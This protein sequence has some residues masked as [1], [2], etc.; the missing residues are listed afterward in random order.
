MQE[1]QQAIDMDFD[2][3]TT[4]LLST[5]ITA[6]VGFTAWI[7]TATQQ[8]MVTPLFTKQRLSDALA[9]MVGPNLATMITGTPTGA[10]MKLN[11]MGWANK[12]TIGGAIL[13]IANQ[14]TRKYTEK[15][16]DGVP[17]FIDAA[18][19]GLIAGGAIGGIFVDPAGGGPAGTY[20]VIGNVAGQGNVPFARGE[21]RN[22][23]LSVV[24]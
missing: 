17:D 12:V 16:I 3:A 1:A 20:T 19:N 11:A 7:Y 9:G 8:Q 14:L 22:G 2:K 13:K 5:A 4:G 6:G 23:H 24:G 10:I 15:Y 18:S 21:A